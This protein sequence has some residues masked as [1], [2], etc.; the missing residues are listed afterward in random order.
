[1][2]APGQSCRELSDRFRFDLEAESNQYPAGTIQQDERILIAKVLFRRVRKRI[3]EVFRGFQPLKDRLLFFLFLSFVRAGRAVAE[4][5]VV[6]IKKIKKVVDT[7][8]VK[9]VDDFTGYLACPATLGGAGYEFI[10][11]LFKRVFGVFQTS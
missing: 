2:R 6:S 9:I 3:P 10:P 4:I 5:V 1:M 7:E 11:F 8:E